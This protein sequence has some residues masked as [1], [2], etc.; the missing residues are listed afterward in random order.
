MPFHIFDH[1]Y[2]S[3]FYHFESDRKNLIV[4]VFLGVAIL[5]SRKEIQI[6]EWIYSYRVSSTDEDIEGKNHCTNI[7]L[8]LR[9]LEMTRHSPVKLGNSCLMPLLRV[10]S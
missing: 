7:P 2:H 10:S 4:L 5:S 1:L 8:L 6:L 9:E 3:S